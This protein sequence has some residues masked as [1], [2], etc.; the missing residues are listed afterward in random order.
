MQAS[1]PSGSARWCALIV[2]CLGSALVL[3]ACSAGSGGST[4]PASSSRAASAVA[5]PISQ[6][7][8]VDPSSLGGVTLASLGFVNGPQGFRVPDGLEQRQR[9]DQTNVVTLVVPGSQG[10]QLYDYLR[11]ALSSLGFTLTAAS[12]DSLIFDAPG[13]EG[14]FTMDDQL[15]GLTLRHL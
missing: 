11:N 2:G 14:A 15:A 3:S 8:S 5:S 13:W 6:A 1:H 9:V 7:P 10:Q 12:G 4:A